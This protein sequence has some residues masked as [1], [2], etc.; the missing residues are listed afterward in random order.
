MVV[1]SAQQPFKGEAGRSNFMA[2]PESRKS[3]HRFEVILK[4]LASIWGDLAFQGIAA[5]AKPS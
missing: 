4:K 5:A 3:L 2:V 1:R